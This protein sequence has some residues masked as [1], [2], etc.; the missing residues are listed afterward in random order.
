MKH[1]SANEWK[2]QSAFVIQ[3]RPETDAA[4]GRYLGRVEHVASYESSHFESLDDFLRFIT[5]VLT[6][7]QTE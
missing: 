6:R 1:K 5:R 4:S 7:V 3:F 2:Y